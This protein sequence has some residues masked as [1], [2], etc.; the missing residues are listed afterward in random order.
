[1]N[2]VWW[3]TMINYLFCGYVIL[4]VVILIEL[5]IMIFPLIKMAR[6]KGWLINLDKFE[7]IKFMECLL[8]EDGKYDIDGY[9]KI[10]KE[11]YLWK[12]KK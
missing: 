12:P 11:E 7:K 3:L 9:R 1:M 8:E 6:A 4:F 2:I 5:G 10:M